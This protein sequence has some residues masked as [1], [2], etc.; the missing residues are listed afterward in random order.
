[1]QFFLIPNGIDEFMDHIV[2]AVSASN[3]LV[4]D[5]N[6]SAVCISNIGNPVYIQYLREVIVPHTRNG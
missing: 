3:G 5:T 4:S 6:G 2:T 1:V